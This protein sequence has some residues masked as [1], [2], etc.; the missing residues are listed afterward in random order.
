MD[1][2][3]DMVADWLRG[4]DLDSPARLATLYLNNADNAGHWHGPEADEWSGA[5]ETV[6]GAVAALV[7][8]LEDERLDELVTVVV[9][10][11]HGMATQSR[12]QVVFLDDWIDLSTVTI[13]SMNPVAHIWPGKPAGGRPH[14]DRRDRHP[15]RGRGRRGHGLPPLR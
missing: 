3:L 11:D 10:S 5:L 4:R 15:G 2:R 7:E 8:R 9:V 1:E 14:D 6:D 13:P 12:D